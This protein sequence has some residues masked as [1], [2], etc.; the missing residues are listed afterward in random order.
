MPKLRENAPP[1][2]VGA[3]SFTLSQAARISGLSTAT[4]RR[5]GA[6]GKLRLFRCGGR[7]MVDGD[8][9]RRMVGVGASE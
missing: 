1:P 3:L 7:R 9:L 5:R 8:S 6:E 4:L 2:M